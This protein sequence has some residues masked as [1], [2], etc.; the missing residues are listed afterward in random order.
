MD[1]EVAERRIER[2]LPGTALQIVH[3]T[4]RPGCPVLVVDISQAGVQLETERPLRPGT[5]V[6]VRL[7]CQEWSLASAALVLRCGVWALHP[8]AGVIYRGALRFE[9]RCALVL[10]DRVNRE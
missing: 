5:R 10:Q 3:A 1:V 9:E 2:R 7:V 4:M 8:D 6:H